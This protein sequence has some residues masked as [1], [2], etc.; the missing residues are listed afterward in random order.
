MDKSEEVVDRPDH[1]RFE[2]NVDGE[3]AIAAYNREGNIVVFTHTEVPEA[4]EGRGVGSALIKGALAHVRA[5]GDR[6]VP[7][8]SFVRAYAERHPEVQDLLAR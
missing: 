4:L 6:F 8:C 7:Q 2:L 3:T 1:H 5:T